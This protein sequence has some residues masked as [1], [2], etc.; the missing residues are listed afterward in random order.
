MAAL[1]LPESVVKPVREERKLNI[2]YIKTRSEETIMAKSIAVSANGQLSYHIEL[3]DS[4]TKLPDYLKNLGYHAEQKICIV[5]DSNVAPLYANEVKEILLSDFPNVFLHVFEAGEA[6]K[7]L[8]TVEKLYEDLIVQHFDRNDFLIALG[9]GVVGDLTGFTAATYLRGIDFIQV[10]TTL[11]SQVDSSIG[12]KTG[13]DFLQ[14]KNMV[15]AF[16]QPKLVYMNL[17]VLHTLPKKQI[18]SGMG[19]LLKHGLIKDAAYFDWMKNNQPKIDALDMETME[20]LIYR[21]CNIKREVVERDPTEKGE[22][23]LLNFG[24]TIGHA[25]EK[26]SDFSLYHGECVGLGIVAASYLSVKLGNITEQEFTEIIKT[27]HAYGFQ[28]QVTGLDAAEVL[29]ATKSDKKM[30]GSKV[31]FIL[32]ESIGHAYIYRELTDEQIL[33]GI[34]YVCK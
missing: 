26:L 16:Y 7:N 20:E 32:L 1:S 5:T 12:G 13:V 33:D 15:G 18:V 4:F 8:K 28:T 9:G 30:V 31:K 34:R 25:I 10:P 11:L 22:R 6:N 17:S 27:L 29:A 14:Y 3:T 21:S 23:A 24:H 2:N 19:E